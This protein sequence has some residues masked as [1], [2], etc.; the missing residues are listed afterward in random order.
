MISIGNGFQLEI[1]HHV[2]TYRPIELGEYPH[3]RQI[4]STGVA[5]LLGGV[6]KSPIALK[7]CSI[8]FQCVRRSLAS[9]QAQRP[10]IGPCHRFFRNSRLMHEQVCRSFIWL[11]KPTKNSDDMVIF[12]NHSVQVKFFKD[13]AGGRCPQPEQE[14]RPALKQMWLCHF[15]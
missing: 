11:L 5:P 12:S 10:E 14:G 3:F 15:A 4:G 6:K 13:S 1:Q 7:D 8:S 9:E 2:A